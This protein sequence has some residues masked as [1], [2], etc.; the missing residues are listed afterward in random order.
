[1]YKVTNN[2]LPDYICDMFEKMNSL[3]ATNFTLRSNTHLNFQIPKPHTEMFKD[4][5]VYSGTVLWNLLPKELKDSGSLRQ[6]KVN[7]LK[8]PGTL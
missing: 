2:D 8:S 7:Y 5:L 1:M 6:F 3:K 4:S